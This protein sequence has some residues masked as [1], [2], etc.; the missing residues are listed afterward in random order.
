MA[1]TLDPA[2]EESR[3]QLEEIGKNGAILLEMVDN[4]LETARIQPGRSGSTW[5]WWT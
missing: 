2:D 3:R 4:V 1:D 5:S